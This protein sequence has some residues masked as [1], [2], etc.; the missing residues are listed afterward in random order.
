MKIIGYVT[1]IILIMVIIT[2]IIISLIWIIL[3]VLG[4]ASSIFTFGMSIP[5]SLGLS[6][7]SGG[8]PLLFIVLS[9]FVFMSH[10][11]LTDY[12]IYKKLKLPSIKYFKY[13]NFHKVM[14]TI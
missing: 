5:V 6:T 1:W 13:L 7:I 8:I 3:S 11:Y 9:M 14:K 4:I 10:G 2:T 12:I